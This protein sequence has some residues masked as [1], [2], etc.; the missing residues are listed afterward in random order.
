VCI[1]HRDHGDSKPG[2]CSFSIT[3]VFPAPTCPP[4]GLYASHS[5][6][7]MRMSRLFPVMMSSHIPSQ[8]CAALPFA[9]SCFA[10][11]SLCSAFIRSTCNVPF[12][13]LILLL[14]LDI[15]PA[16]RAVTHF[17]VNVSPGLNNQF[18]PSMI[19][20]QAGDSVEFIL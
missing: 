10:R 8:S 4:L 17:Q 18:T 19:H 16:V 13:F 12:L 7:M 6:R 15:L 20:A 1:T 9:V 5:S 2:H 11:R 14:T 3:R